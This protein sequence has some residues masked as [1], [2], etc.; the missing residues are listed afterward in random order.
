MQEQL[1]TTAR[2]QEVEQC[3]S[4]CRDTKRAKFF[5]L[6]LFV[7]FAERLSYQ[8]NLAAGVQALPALASG[9]CIPV[10]LLA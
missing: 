1:P 5:N 9:A 10:H 7:S 2:M 6:V 8:N 3:R 4:N